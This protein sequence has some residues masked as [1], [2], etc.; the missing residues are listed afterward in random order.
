MYEAA[1]VLTADPEDKWLTIGEGPLGLNAI[2]LGDKGVRD[3]LASDISD[4]LLKKSK[5]EGHIAK[6]AVENRTGAESPSCGHER[7]EPSLY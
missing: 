7:L 1:D 6:Y 5:E 3:V 4:T 2:R